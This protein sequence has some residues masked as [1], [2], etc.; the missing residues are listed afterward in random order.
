M[1]LLNKR[2]Y[3][4]HIVSPLLTRRLYCRRKVTLLSASTLR[5]LT[6]ITSHSMCVVCVSMSVCVCVHNYECV[7]PSTYSLIHSSIDLCSLQ[8]IELS[9][10]QLIYLLLCLSINCDKFVITFNQSDHACTSTFCI[11]NY[12]L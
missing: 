12:E 11:Y 6:L 2:L 8:S 3:Y 1:P 9:I 10:H 5:I 4:R 7:Y